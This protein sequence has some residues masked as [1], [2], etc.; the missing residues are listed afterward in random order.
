MSNETI[1]VLNN[2]LVMLILA[3]ELLIV[4]VEL[5]FCSERNVKKLIRIN[6]RLKR[7]E[8]KVDKL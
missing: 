2:W 4:G 5:R 6:A 7:I 3:G 8:E 1:K